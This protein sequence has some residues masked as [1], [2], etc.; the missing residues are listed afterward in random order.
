M[1]QSKINVRYAKALFSLG[2]ELGLTD[3]LRDDVEFVETLCRE[4]AAFIQLLE[5]PVVSISKKKA[6]VQAIL[7]PY[8]SDL[9]LRFFLL[10]IEKQREAN[11]PGISRN[12]LDLVRTS[13]G[14]VPALI[15]T[16]GKLSEDTLTA[17]RKSLEAETG[18]IIELTDKVNPGLIGGMVIRIVD[19]QYD[20]SVATRLKKVKSALLGK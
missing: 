13:R 10:I 16:A 6:V 9:G 11:I 18:M 1:N 17:I 3:K 7:K 15:T 8:V 20:G 5:N 4:S 14:I 19:K 12:F 2:E